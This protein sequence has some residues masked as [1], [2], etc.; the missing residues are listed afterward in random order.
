M[1]I[2]KRV[3]VSDIHMSP[4][5]SLKNPQ[6]CYDW[7]S[8]EQATQFDVFL[9][10]LIGDKTIEEVILLGDLMDGW[11]YPIEVQPPKYDKIAGA[12]H[13]RDIMTDLQELAKVK[14]VTYVIGNHD[15]TLG[16]LQF[17][18]FRQSIFPG[19]SFHN[20]YET[21]DGLYAEHGHQYTMYNAVDP[22]H[23]LPLGHYISRL[24]ATVAERKQHFYINADFDKNFPAA[25]TYQFDAKGFIKDPLVN[26]PLSFLE[27]ELGN[28]DDNTPI[29]TVNGGVITLSE[30]R[31]QYAKL[32]IDWI[33][34]HG[35]LS[36]FRSVWRE[37]V[38]LDGVA[39]QIASGKV[40]KGK[41]YK[42]VIFGHTHNKENR[43]LSLQ[44]P[45]VASG[46]EETPYAIYANCGAWCQDKKPTY[47]IDE[48]DDGTGKHKVT[49]KFWGEDQEIVN[50][51]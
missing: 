10:T 26:A 48:Y 7:F 24:A 27:E 31:Q 5:L 38:G 8:E 47:V 22:K 12:G 16:E 46:S 36:G 42:I 2:K 4:G 17:E 13:I 9:K 20:S 3:F 40:F 18:N 34:K 6:S 39:D 15:M 43:R 28:V 30:V 23:E 51:I 19:I 29:T 44:S 45:A 1:P 14:R 35:L 21:D 11:V 33:E 50:T 41:N 25:G 49:L 32:G 37:A